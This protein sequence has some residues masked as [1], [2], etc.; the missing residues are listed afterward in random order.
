M[1]LSPSLPPSLS[2]SPLSPLWFLCSSLCTSVHEKTAVPLYLRWSLCVTSGNTF[3]FWHTMAGRG[4]SSSWFGPPSLHSHCTFS[5]RCNNSPL[6]NTTSECYKCIYS[7]A[8]VTHAARH[9][10]CKRKKKNNNKQTSLGWHL[11]R[12]Q[13]S[14]ILVCDL[15]LPWRG[16]ACFYDF[17]FN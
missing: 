11:G 9:K 13:F 14:V 16:Y 5:Q 1:L 6:L 17:F 10:P 3:R 8:L 7:P 15:T 2:P 12:P 4:A